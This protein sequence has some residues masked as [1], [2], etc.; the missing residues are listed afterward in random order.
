MHATHQ[1]ATA[2]AAC[3]HSG[4]NPSGRSDVL[5]RPRAIIAE[6]QPFTRA[7]FTVAALS[8]S[9]GVIPAMTYDIS[10]PCRLNACGES[11]PAVIFA[12]AFMTS[13]TIL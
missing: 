10:S 13:I 4:R 2:L 12:P 9:Y 11:V 6:D 3:E 8:A 1:L 5:P 7:E